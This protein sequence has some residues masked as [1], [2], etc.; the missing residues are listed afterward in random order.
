MRVRVA[1]AGVMLIA[2]IVGLIFYVGWSID[3]N[4]RKSCGMYN[5]VYRNTQRN[6]LPEDPELRRNTL[7]FR[8][9][10]GVLREAYHCDR[11]GQPDVDN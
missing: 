7:E 3:Q 2:L 6:P 11:V 10:L 8:K 9:E 1:Y 5:L 4:N